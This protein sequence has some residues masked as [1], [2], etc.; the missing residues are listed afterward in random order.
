MHPSRH[1]VTEIEFMSVVKWR[2]L[3]LQMSRHQFRY[4]MSITQ[5]EI[6]LGGPFGV[7]SL[8]AWD[9]SSY[10]RLI[11]I[12]KVVK[13]AWRDGSTAPHHRTKCCFNYTSTLFYPDASFRSKSLKW[14]GGGEK[15]DTHTVRRTGEKVMKMIFMLKWQWRLLSS[16]L[17]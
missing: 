2:K 8:I 11:S 12:R 17:I 3:M 16:L 15:K 9:I 4:R 1:K 10:C 7:T 5:S 13:E 6:N 14:S